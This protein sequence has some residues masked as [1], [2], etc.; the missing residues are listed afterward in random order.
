M[1]Y[2]FIESDD[3]FSSFLEHQL[4]VVNK[5][6]KILRNYHPFLTKIHPDIHQ[7]KTIRTIVRKMVAN[8]L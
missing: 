1:S 8:M 6:H 7:N 5:N 4:L 3:I 2:A